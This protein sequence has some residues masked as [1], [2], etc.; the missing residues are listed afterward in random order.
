MSQA[1]DAAGGSERVT[2]AVR[3][4]AG[5]FGAAVLGRVAAN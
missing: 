4:R 5:V 1:Q 3:D 2:R